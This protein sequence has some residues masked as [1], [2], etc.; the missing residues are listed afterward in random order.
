M[1]WNIMVNKWFVRCYNYYA[2]TTV[3]ACSFW[4]KHEDL[5][6][7]RKIKIFVKDQQPSLTLSVVYVT[8]AT[9]ERRFLKNN[10]VKKP[11]LLNSPKP[12]PSI[13]ANSI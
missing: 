6:S 2:E 1:S 4:A 7:K 12:A 8:Y 9:L 3:P 10:K 13:Y 5:K 11:R